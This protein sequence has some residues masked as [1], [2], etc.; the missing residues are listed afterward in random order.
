MEESIEVKKNTYE[1][2]AENLPPDS[3]DY[4]LNVNYIPSKAY[5]M[6]KDEFQPSDVNVHPKDTRK[7]QFDFF[8]EASLYGYDETRY[9]SKVSTQNFG[10]IP[11]S[12]YTSLFVNS[13]IGLFAELLRE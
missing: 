13:S 9:V 6:K 2:T 8:S 4:I 5:F 12:E 10:W 1:I 11:P 3:Q 7:L